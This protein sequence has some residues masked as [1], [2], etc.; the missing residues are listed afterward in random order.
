MTSSLT[1]CWFEV[2]WF[3]GGCFCFW[4]VLWVRWGLILLG[5]RLSGTAFVPKKVPL[6]FKKQIWKS[7]K[8][9]LKSLNKLK[10]V[11]NLRIVL[12]VF[13]LKNHKNP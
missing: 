4:V 13:S 12:M 5:F 8:Q 1:A 11:K 9:T 6:R 7:N 3:F 2:G 10:G